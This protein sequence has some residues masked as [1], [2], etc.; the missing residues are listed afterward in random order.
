MAKPAS[1]KVASG[2]DVAGREVAGRVVAELGRPETPDETAARR[3]ETSRAHRA[4]QTTRNLVL[5]IIASLGIVLFAV[6]VVVRPSTSLVKA[7]DYRAVAAQAQPAVDAKLAAPA[8]PK[9]WASN[10]AELK[11]DSGETIDWYVGLI[12]PKQQ[13]IAIEQGVD[14]SDTWFGS[15][16]GKSPVTGH[17]TIAGVRWVVYNR[18]QASPTGNFAYSLAGSIGTSHFVLHGS[19]DK[20]EFSQLATAIAKEL[21]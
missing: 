5:A 8:L 12:T 15:L 6:L 14:T 16:L 11:T 7:V 4:N 9:G 2:R 13:F 19:A 21:K 1:E 20:A 3:A 18:R 10:D 17:L